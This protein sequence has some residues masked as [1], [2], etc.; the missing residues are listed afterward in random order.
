MGVPEALD[1][2]EIVPQPGEQLAPD[3]VSVQ[4]TPLLCES[5]CTVAVKACVPMPA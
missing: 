5:F 1:V 4:L 2:A 3:C